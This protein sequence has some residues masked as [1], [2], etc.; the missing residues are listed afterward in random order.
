MSVFYIDMD[1]VL[2]NFS[3]EKN[4]RNRYIKEQLFFKFLRP[5][6]VN[7]KAA[8]CLIKNGEQV[9]VITKSPHRAADKAKREWLK[10]FLP[11]LG[12]NNIIIVREG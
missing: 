7:V 9:F 12:Q 10:R 3:A 5:I 6:W 2:A 11:E 4:G 1:D 8:N